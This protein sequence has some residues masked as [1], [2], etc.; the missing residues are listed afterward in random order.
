LLLEAGHTWAA[1]RDKMDWNDALIDRSSKRFQE[2]WLAGFFCSRYS[3]CEAAIETG[4]STQVNNEPPCERLAMAHRG[5][6]MFFQKNF[7]GLNA[8]TV[9]QGSP[10]VA[11][12]TGCTVHLREASG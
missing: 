8:D 9:R 4:V 5:S 12:R 11:S 10:Y 1:I 3:F 6:E 2:E 7:S